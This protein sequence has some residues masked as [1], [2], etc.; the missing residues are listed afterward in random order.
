MKS[1]IF[2]KEEIIL[3]SSIL[4]FFLLKFLTIHPTFSDENLYFLMGKK[5]KEG[6]IPY[7]DFSYVHPPLQLYTYALFFH[8][9]GVSLHTAKLVPLLA[10]SFSVALV[11][12][13]SRKLFNSKTALLSS[14]FFLL[15][16][17]FLTFSDQGY[18]TWEALAF[19][20]LSFHFAL[21]HKPILS[22]FS[23]TIALFFRYLALTYLPFL[24]LYFLFFEKSE[25]KKFVLSLSSLALSTF[26][27]LF[28]IFGYNFIHD[29][30]IFQFFSRL[31]STK[32]K[33]I[34]QYLNFGFFTI[35]LCLVSSLVLSRQENKKYMLFSL[36][37]LLVD[38]IL[39]LS[40]KNIAYHYFLFSLP[41]IMIATSSA[42]LLSKEISVKVFLLLIFFLSFYTN[43]ST[44]E[45]YINP[46]RFT[47]IYQVKELIQ[48]RTKE[49]E[50]IFGEYSTTSFIS[51]STGIEITSNYFDTFLDYLKFV[52]ESK[53]LE[54]LMK[55]KPAFF[56]DAE[57]Y[58]MSEESFNRF[59]RENYILEMEIEGL[60]SYKVYRKI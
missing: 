13:I 17:A 51:F 10:S 23:F 58:L 14:I 25:L 35:F 59:I 33:L 50:T 7:K 29:T 28:S 9:F 2:S 4:I 11:F 41:F 45:F 40:F 21:D 38:S 22:A 18:G 42:F 5:V 46:K 27:L 49:G 55:K 60:P 15:F 43:F 24:L 57:E 20:L 36:Y 12:F 3:F 53:I 6:L 34:F 48:N 26:L 19:L 39:L 47:S 32:P 44:L 52:N 16:P 31:I 54:E 56:I 8:L 30:I 37:P 1:E